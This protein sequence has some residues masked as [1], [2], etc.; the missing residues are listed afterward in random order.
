MRTRPAP[1]ENRPTPNFDRLARLY[2]WLEYASFGPMLERCRFYFLPACATA[3]RALI[4]GDGDGRFTQRLLQANPFLE[5]DAVDA[6]AQMLQQLRQRV[7]SSGTDDALRVHTLRADI[8]AFTPERRDNDP[9]Y[10]LVVSHFFLDC[11]TPNEIDAL[12]DRLRECLAPDALWLI[13]DFAI[14]QRGWLR[15]VAQLVVRSL[16]FAFDCL[17]RLRIKKLPD[18]AGALEQHGF[19]QVQQKTFLGGLLTTELWQKQSSKP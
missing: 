5:V 7:A 2:R 14:P 13:S 12:A 11:L 1:N 10:D 19:F 8:R 17:T 9:G 6:S 16:Y 4:L 18:Y 15:P 3:R